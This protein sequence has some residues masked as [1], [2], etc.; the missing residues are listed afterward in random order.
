MKLF[1]LDLFMFSL[2]HTLMR[3]KYFMNFF[4]Q[5]LILYLFFILCKQ[6]QANSNVE[7]HGLRN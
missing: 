3:N 6:Q 7:N 4:K 2:S 1:I 5:G